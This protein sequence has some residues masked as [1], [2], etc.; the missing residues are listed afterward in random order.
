M[1]IIFE[2]TKM[3]TQLEATIVLLLNQ[4]L[5]PLERVEVLDI[6][7][8]YFNQYERIEDICRVLEEATNIL[9]R[10]DPNELSSKLRLIP[11]KLAYYQDDLETTLIA[12]LVALYSDVA[13]AYGAVGDF[14]NS[15]CMALKSYQLAQRL[16][17]RHLQ[18]GAA[19]EYGAACIGLKKYE[20][21]LA[22]GEEALA[23]GNYVSTDVVRNNL[24]SSYSLLG[25]HDDVIHH[26]EILARESSFP[27]LRAAS[28]SRIAQIHVKHQRLP[29]AEQAFENTLID[30]PEIQDDA[31]IA[32]IVINLIEHGNARQQTVAAS[33]FSRISTKSLSERMNERLALAKQKWQEQL[34]EYS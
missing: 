21:W 1:A 9:K 5:E 25:R 2:E 30:L 22:I 19:A 11:A 27:K 12:D 23:L 34:N 8:N 4:N 15:E 32:S 16:K 14:E 20:Q 17:I 29:E 18:V 13:S 7:S 28:W 6:Q 3:H 10:F 31:A 24:V 33:H 26:S